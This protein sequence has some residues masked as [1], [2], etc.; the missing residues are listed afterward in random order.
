[1]RRKG[2]RGNLGDE[3]NSISRKV[4]E[5]EQRREEEELC[6]FMEIVRRSEEDQARTGERE[7]EG[8]RGRGVE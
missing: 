4:V 6:P 7:R 1:M 3:F 2:E 8:E 5:R